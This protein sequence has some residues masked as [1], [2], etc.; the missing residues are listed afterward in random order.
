MVKNLCPVAVRLKP[1][2]EWRAVGGEVIAIDP[3]TSSYLAVNDSGAALWPMVEAGATRAQLAG[4]LVTRF[5]IDPER[6]QEDVDAFVDGLHRLGLL[7]GAGSPSD[8][9]DPLH[10][11][12]GPNRSHTQD[13]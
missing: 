13:D 11:G 2:I 6:A 8:T 3:T 4:E 9:A 1:G 12:G 5:R 7:T 10:Q